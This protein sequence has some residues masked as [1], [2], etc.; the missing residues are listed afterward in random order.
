MKHLIKPTLVAAALTM[1]M[2]VAHAEWPDK[3]IKLVVPY[4]AGGAADNTAR[5]L[6]QHLGERLKQ[7]IIVD[8]R[9][10]AS[11]TIGASA[12]AKSPADGYTLL[13]DA[14][15][16]A[17]NPSLFPKLNYDPTK[18]FSPISLV[19]QVPLLLVVP[20]KSPYGS[21]PEII[22]AAREKPGTLTFASAGSG[23]AQ[24]LAAELFAQSEKISLTHIPYKGGAPALTDLIGGQVDLMFSATSASGSFVKGGKL[25]AIAITS[26][27]RVDT[28]PQTPTVAES[29]I[30]GFEVSEWNGLFA[31]ANTPRAIVERLEA[32]TRA[33][34]ASPAVAKRFA[35]AGVQGVGSSSQDFAA[36]VKSETAKW[37]K[38]IKAGNIK[39]D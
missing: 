8:N 33:V 5:I 10:G 21:V 25:K 11:G 1:A 3:P 34:V 24:H 26:A 2:G 28:W 16:H 6:A 7:Q 14:T 19:V 31:P 13:L 17:V 39:S 29:A 23:G 36:F 4:P 18:D 20:S 27:K 9:P 32:E 30:P 35:E 37:A 22:K 15:S 38:V 12:V